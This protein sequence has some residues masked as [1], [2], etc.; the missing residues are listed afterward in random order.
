MGTRFHALSA[1]DAVVHA[2]GT[3]GGIQANMQE[4][5]RSMVE[6]ADVGCNVILG[7]LARLASFNRRRR[8]GEYRV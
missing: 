7:A 3:V 8:S 4:R 2:A 1:T 6:S 5:A